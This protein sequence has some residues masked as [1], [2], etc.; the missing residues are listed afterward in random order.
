MS[1]L[2]LRLRHTTFHLTPTNL[3]KIPGSKLAR[4][5]NDKCKNLLLQPE[6]DMNDRLIDNKSDEA[7][8]EFD[9]SPLLFS[10]IYDAVLDGHLHLPQRLCHQALHGELVFW[11]INPQ[12]LQPC[13]YGVYEAERDKLDKIEAIKK[14]W[15]PRCVT[16]NYDHTKFDDYEHSWRQKMW[17]TLENPRSS[18][19]AMVI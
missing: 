8:F 4:L 5:A 7:D 9:R 13:C 3:A 10:V 15:P 2:S 16:D 17:I 12:L 18:T 11:D 1:G 6:M 19:A 14:Q